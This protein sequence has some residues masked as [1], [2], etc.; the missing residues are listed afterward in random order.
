MALYRLCLATFL[1][2]AAC[3]TSSGTLTPTPAPEPETPVVTTPD[4]EPEPEAIVSDGTPADPEDYIGVLYPAPYVGVRSD[5]STTRGMGT[6][7]VVSTSEIVITVDGRSL[8]LTDPE[9]D[10]TFAGS[11]G[12]AQQF[13][14][15]SDLIYAYVNSLGLYTTGY[16]FQTAPGDIVSVSSG[17]YALAGGSVLYLTSDGSR[18]QSLSG[19]VAMTVDFENGIVAGTVFQNGGLTLGLTGGTVDA[20]GNISGGLTA[21]GFGANV[22]T[23]DLDA[24]FYGSG[25]GNVSGTYE[26][27]FDANASGGANGFL[28]GFTAYEN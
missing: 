5:N 19:N 6:I 21:A 13:A 4:P 27:T 12:S 15:S 17:S 20:Q 8:T 28:G 23:S 10:G 16:G 9:G 1:A 2:L 14:I 7:R 24:R 25:A 26:G 3:D 22:A 11:D 18:V